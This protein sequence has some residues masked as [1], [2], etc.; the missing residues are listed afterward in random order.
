MN[1]FRGFW[2]L[3][4]PTL[5]MGSLSG[6]FQSEPLSI[7][8][9]AQLA[10]E[11]SEFKK[12]RDLSNQALALDAEN[13]L[14]YLVRGRTKLEQGEIDLAIKDYSKAMRLVPTDPEPYYFRADAYE[15]L[16][17]EKEART[18]RHEGR[19][20]DP[21]A[22]GFI[23][24]PEQLAAEI[25]MSR[26]FEL[27]KEPETDLDPNST[28]DV[29]SNSEFEE[30]PKP[31]FETP[32]NRWK[33]E[34]DSEEDE[35]PK[36]E[37]IVN[38]FRK[39]EPSPNDWREKLPLSETNLS[40]LKQPSME[41]ITPDVPTPI[42]KF[43]SWKD[44]LMQFEQSQELSLSPTINDESDKSD[45]LQP[46]P[47]T[48]PHRNNQKTESPRSPI[49]TPFQRNWQ[50]SGGLSDPLPPSDVNAGFLPPL[51]GPAVSSTGLN[52]TGLN[53]SRT[54]GPM[55]Q[56]YPR[57]STNSTMPNLARWRK[58]SRQTPNTNV[59]ATTPLRSQGKTF[60]RNYLLPRTGPSSG[61]QPSQRTTG[62]R[63]TTIP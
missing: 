54:T 18:D 7:I 61:F 21:L 48:P 2:L 55:P 42:E 40:R 53:A 12:A 43:Q 22:K 39:N 31:L 49:I 51:L 56:T 36:R 25:M 63:S 3:L 46:P 57:T 34:R 47:E 20:H 60:R 62:I 58:F 13:H 50:L 35:T 44:G 23:Y 32:N 5:I 16:G 11:N 26:Q 27:E 10:F 17:K 33:T 28:D 4:V 9:Q 6:C 41:S 37:S 29:T 38:K 19:R 1:L 24:E 52:A 8:E 59:P 45:R 15:L 30:S 14:A